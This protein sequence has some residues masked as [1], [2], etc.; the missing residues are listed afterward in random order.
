MPIFI[1]TEWR[2]ARQ[3]RLMQ[4]TRF[5]VQSCCGKT[6]VISKTDQPLTKELLAKFIELGFREAAHFTTAGI[7]YADN[8]DL[9]I[10]GPI[11]SNQLQIKCKKEL[12]CDQKI[13]DF[14]ALIKT[15]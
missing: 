11:G 6:S 1:G 7:L 3:Q 15:I 12:N 10:T 9:I 4:I 8:T 2:R 5:T 13:N 14:E